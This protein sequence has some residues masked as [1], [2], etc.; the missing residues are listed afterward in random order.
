M[1]RFENVIAV[2]FGA[3]FL[4]LSLLV[5]VETLARK[6]FS[7]SL[8]GVDELG[9]Y[10]LAVG[11]ALA[12]TSAF[13]RGAHIRIDILHERLPRI[14]QL[15][16]NVLSVAALATCAGLM[17]AMA[18][19]SFWESVAYRSTVMSPWATPLRYPQFAWLVALAIFAALTA[20]AAARVLSLLVRRRFAEINR[21]YSPFSAKSELAEEVADIQTRGALQAANAAPGRQP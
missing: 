10:F 16:L 9:G 15:A 13:A 17:L 8:Q 14:L 7:V 20:A 3:M 11:G 5:S 12:F 1:K 18:W 2:T 6:L 19:N 4:L 21:E